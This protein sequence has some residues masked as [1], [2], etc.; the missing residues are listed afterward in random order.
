MN[1]DS[2]MLVEQRRI[3]QAFDELAGRAAPPDRSDE[4]LARVAR[5]ERAPTARVTAPRSMRLLVA[6]VVLLGLAV[7]AFA[8]MSE[9][10][11]ERDEPVDDAVVRDDVP[12]P[13]SDAEL[14]KGADPA[15]L[16]VLRSEKQMLTAEVQFA[17]MVREGRIGGADHVLR[18]EQLADWS[19]VDGLEGMPS[20]VAALSGESVAMIGFMLPIDEVEQMRRFLLVESLWSCC[21]GQP[22]DIHGIVRV[23][24]PKGKTTDYF[25]DPL[26]IIGTFKVEATVMDG[27]CV[28]I[29]QLHVE[30]LEPIRFQ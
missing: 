27:Y 14:P 26:K 13:K 8:M 11:H 12:P 18:F 6:A 19:Y 20:E 21:Y 5:G 2:D 15:D 17:D 25:F 1:E 7:V 3:E 29:Y 10:A 28:D 30:S 22:P 16:R 9:R 4:I 23:V 24:M